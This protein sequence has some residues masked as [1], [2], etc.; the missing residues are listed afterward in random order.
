MNGKIIYIATIGKNGEV[1][2]VHVH[3]RAKLFFAAGYKTEVISEC[4]YDNYKYVDDKYLTHHYLKPYKGSGKLRGLVWWE[5]QLLGLSTF[6]QIKRI[7]QK[8]QPQYV[9][10]YEISSIILIIRLKAYCQKRGIKLIVEVS[11][12]MEVKDYKFPYQIIV[13]LKDFQRHHLD[14]KIGNIITISNYL[15]C[16]YSNRKC[17]KVTIPPLFDTLVHET[18]IK[19][20]PHELCDAKI[21]LVFAGSIGN[22]DYLIPLIKTI[23]KI[24]KDKIQIAFDVIGPS[25]EDIAK[26]MNIQNM[27]NHGVFLMGMLSHEETIEIVKKADFSVLFRENRRYAKAGVSTKFCE[28]MRLGVPSI[29]TKVGGTDIFV[30]DGENG[31]LIEDN[32]EENITQ[33]LERLVRLNNEELY[34]LK[35]NAYHSAFRYFS[36]DSHIESVKEFLDNCQ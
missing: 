30:K 15:F 4:P 11:E 2:A 27:Q 31:F 32:T 28:A 1:G 14:E 18:E 5:E 13:G 6:V 19:R 17:N 22:K 16:N 29:C 12:W 8:E 34:R 36:I 26:M 23:L 35:I 3:N 20:H 9:V 21:R 24:N 7:L 33:M 10:A 25:K